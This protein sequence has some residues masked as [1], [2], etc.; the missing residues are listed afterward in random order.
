MISLVVFCG[1]FLLGSFLKR[2]VDIQAD[3]A[4]L[5]AQIMAERSINARLQKSID[6]WNKLASPQNR[7]AMHNHQ[8]KYTPN[9]W[10]DLGIAPTH[11]KNAIMK[12][13]RLK[14]KKAHPD[15]GGNAYAFQKLFEAKIQALRQCK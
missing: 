2:I 15:H 14:A 6:E 1:F 7:T 12:A 13:F 9:Y 10:N 3:Q 5:R 11:D 4:P 8:Q